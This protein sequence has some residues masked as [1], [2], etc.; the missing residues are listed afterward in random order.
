MRLAGA[1][2]GP[3]RVELG[4]APFRPG[5]RHRLGPSALAAWP[6]ELRRQLRDHRA[7]HDHLTVAEAAGRTPC[8]LDARPA[9]LIDRD[10]TLVLLDWSFTGDGAI[11]KDVANLIIDSCT[12]GLTDAALLPEIAGSVTR[13]YLT[14]LRDA[15]RS[16]VAE[17]RHRAREAPGVAGGIRRRLGCTWDPGRAG[18]PF[19]P[20]FRV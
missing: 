15:G 17:I 12:D 1:V 7:D 20:P 10:G 3:L 16:G 14:G 19:L 5:N 2:S 9:N 18:V 13:G 4:A 6:A 11:G 8:H